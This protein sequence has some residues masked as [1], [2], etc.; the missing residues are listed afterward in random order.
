MELKCVSGIFSRTYDVISLS[1]I[2]SKQVLPGHFD[3]DRGSPSLKSNCVSTDF[4]FLFCWIISGSSPNHQWITRFLRYRPAYCTM[5]IG[6]CVLESWSIFTQKHVNGIL[7]IFLHRLSML[8]LTC[9]NSWPDPRL[10]A[11][12]LTEFKHKML[13]DWRLVVTE[14]MWKIPEYSNSFT[15]YISHNHQASVNTNIV[16]QENT[17]Q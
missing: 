13:H 1:K 17:W 8:I 14:T 4:H 6:R 15:V 16:T 2:R 12:N 3:S 10:S 5:I 9:R 11:S 7:E